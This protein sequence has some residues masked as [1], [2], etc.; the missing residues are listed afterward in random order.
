[1]RSR[2]GRRGEPTPSCE[3]LQPLPRRKLR[4]PA[5]GNAAVLLAALLLGACG[6][7]TSRLPT[8]ESAS[9]SPAL[10]PLQGQGQLYG[11]INASGSFVIPPQYAEAGPFRDGLAAVAVGDLLHRKYGF[12]APSG[13]FVISPQYDDVGWFSEGLASI[14]MAH[15]VGFIDK[16]GG[17]IIAPR[18]DRVIA[19]HDGVAPV[20]V[21]GQ[22]GLIDRSGNFLINPIFENVFENAEGLSAVKIRGQYGYIDTKG[23]FAINPQLAASY[24]F[25]EGLG[26]FQS[27]GGKWGCLNREGQV[28]VA[29]TFDEARNFREGLAAVRIG[30]SFGFIDK[31][32]KLLIAPRFEDV[33]GIPNGFSEGTAAVSIGQKWG[34]IDRSGKIVIAPQFGGGALDD[35]LNDWSFH[36]GIA[37]VLIAGKPGYINRSGKL[38]AIADQ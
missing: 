31:S 24:S 14:T 21:A 26:A 10:R 17:L 22:W 4:S 29:A 18:F 16:Q 13:K 25:A 5:I 28:V 8:G 37:S 15:L 6:S 30:R 1:M 33:G 36:D 20:R 2:S 12:I 38:I 35:S 19:F 3:V 34:Y 27:S 9:S 7:G 32:G 23:K 11:Y